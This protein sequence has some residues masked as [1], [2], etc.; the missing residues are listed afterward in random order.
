[1]SEIFK[2]IW[3]NPRI[4]QIFKERRAKQ[5]FPIKD[6]LPEIKIQNFLRQLNIEFIPHKNIREIEHRYQCD[7]FIPS[8]NLV[9][10]CD[11]DYWHGNTNNPRFKNLNKFQINTKERDNIRIKELQEKGF[12]VLRFWESDIEKM[13]LKDF[14]DRIKIFRKSY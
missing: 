6:S 2:K 3:R 9:I 7:I 8:M 10:E 11:G 14:M 5:I 13:D 1:M 12:N 4:R